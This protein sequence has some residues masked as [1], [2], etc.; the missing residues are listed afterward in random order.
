MKA[1]ETDVSELKNIGPKTAEWLRAVG[2][3]TRRDLEQ[4]VSV[5]TYQTIRA[6]GF[7]SALLLLYA[8]EGALLDIHWNRL[9]AELKSNLKSAAN[10]FNP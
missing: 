2:V 7:N 1:S 5:H 10:E 3:Y 9:P 6:H 8:L 4:L